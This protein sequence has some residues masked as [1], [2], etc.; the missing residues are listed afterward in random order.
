LLHDNLRTHSLASYKNDNYY[1]IKT[2]SNYK[3]QQNKADQN[4]KGKISRIIYK[5]L[6]VQVMK[7]N[8]RVEAQQH[9]ALH[10]D[11]RST[12]HFSHFTPEERASG[13]H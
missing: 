9:T 8:G 2:C 13:A 7:I 11:V 3:I 5:V 1:G 12:S 6:P 4:T 10:A